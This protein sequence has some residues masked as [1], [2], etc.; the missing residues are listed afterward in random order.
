MACKV[1]GFLCV[2]W[3]IAPILILQSSMVLPPSTR[4]VQVAVIAQSANGKANELLLIDVDTGHSDTI[5][6]DVSLVAT[7][8]VEGQSVIA[9]S[10]IKNDLNVSVLGRKDSTRTVSIPGAAFFLKFSDDG[11]SIIIGLRTRNPSSG[12]VELA[13]CVTDWRKPA[14]EWFQNLVKISGDLAGVE[15]GGVLSPTPGA[16]G[17][18]IWIQAVQVKDANIPLIADYSDGFMQSSIVI[19]EK[20]SVKH[21][22]HLP[23]TA[24]VVATSSDNHVVCISG[25]FKGDSLLRLANLNLITG[26]LEFLSDDPNLVRVL[27]MDLNKMSALIIKHDP[28]R[29]ERVAAYVNLLDN[30]IVMKWENVGDDETVGKILG[31]K[32]VLMVTAD[33][34]LLVN[35]A[36][37]KVFRKMR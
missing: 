25:K 37:K 20:R 13:L 26:N 35:L 9:Y 15:G 18:E 32:Q 33:Q 22:I 23:L 5:A 29:D 11:S 2:L 24:R 7:S 14:D 17:R 8:N 6:S 31:D 16:G 10:N 28:Q 12:R 19:T 34:V 4:P 1:L 30:T 27:D 36:E 21:V 3:L